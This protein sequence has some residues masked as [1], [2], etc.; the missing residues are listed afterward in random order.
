[1]KWTHF[2]GV[3]LLLLLFLSGCGENGATPP[4]AETAPAPTATSMPASPTP[5]PTVTPIP[6]EP[7]TATP[8]PPTP[9]ATPD[10]SP[11]PVVYAI[12]EGD[13]ALGLADRLGVTLEQIQA[14]NPGVDLTLLR[15][16]QTLVLPNSAE[17]GSLPT[18]TPAIAEPTA[19]PTIAAVAPDALPLEIVGYRQVRATDSSVWVLG[20]LV[21]RGDQPVEDAYIL[22][23]TD[24]LAL[25]ISAAA[26]HIAPGEA[27][28]FGTLVQDQTTDA[29]ISAEIQGGILTSTD[30]T[31][32]QPLAVNAPS[33]SVS[34]GAVTLEG[35]VVNDTDSAVADVQLTASFFDEDGTLVGFQ[36]LRQ[37]D[38]LE[39]GASRAFRLTSSPPGGSAEGYTLIA[40]GLKQP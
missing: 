12:Q 24:A 17:T 26:G 29:P 22:L 15:I 28:P 40:I 18:A 31:R 16:G 7:P 8:A 38:P 6:T 34:D 19:V 11:T 14:L 33:F 1:M 13:T 9:T 30:A 5:L 2:A 32:Y 27:V 37:L 39:A 10:A 36:I 21:N 20:E 3:G 25:T 35:T 23:Q 4:S